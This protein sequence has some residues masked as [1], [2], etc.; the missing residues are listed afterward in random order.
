MHNIQQ[1]DA[2]IV[3]TTQSMKWKKNI[4]GCGF[5]FG[6]DIVAAVGMSW[7]DVGADH[8]PVLAADMWIFGWYVVDAEHPPD[9]AAD[10]HAPPSQHVFSHCCRYRQIHPPILACKFLALQM[11]LLYIC[12]C[13]TLLDPSLCWNDAETD[14][15]QKESMPI[16]DKKI[17]WM[18]NQQL[19]MLP[20]FSQ[21]FFSPIRSPRLIN[22]TATTFWHQCNGPVVRESYILFVY[23]RFDLMFVI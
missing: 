18:G 2:H 3:V 12:T 11:Y 8:S 19:S 15:Q 7:Y 6:V 17:I 21:S 22:E 10:L 13:R 4:Q 1:T 23:L 14:D 5:L 16:I 20:F 9:L